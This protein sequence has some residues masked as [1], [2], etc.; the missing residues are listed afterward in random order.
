[1]AKP[2]NL[3][4][5][6][7]G[8]LTAVKDV[9]KNKWG[10][11]LWLCH[12][13]CGNEITVAA[14]YLIKGE[15]RS[16]GCLKKERD[17]LQ[18]EDLTGRKFGRLTVICRAKNKKN[19]VMWLCKCDCGNKIIA[20]PNHLKSGHTTSC[21]C[22]QRESNK[23]RIGDIDGSSIGI[24]ETKKAHPSNRLGIR[25]VSE[26][27]GKFIAHMRFKGKNVL[28]KTFDNLEDAIKARQDAV[29]RYAKPYVNENIADVQKKREAVKQR[30]KERLR[31]DEKEKV[32]HDGK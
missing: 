26:R 17:I 1:M 2:Q 25:G 20:D 4:G 18:A 32:K 8:R 31:V 9:G 15:A 5:R 7:F 13:D 23:K 11:R 29:E 10:N 30:R 19:R 21:G 14:T 27:N 16:C 6:K 12:C 22:V 28:Y 3:V 24:W